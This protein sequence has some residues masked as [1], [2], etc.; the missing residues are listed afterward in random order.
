MRP[1]QYR[2]NDYSLLTPLFKKWI[3]SPLIRFVPWAIPANI[4]TLVSNVFV[5]LGLL[6][7]LNPEI[8]RQYTALLIALCLLAYLIGDHLDGMQAKRTGT[9]SALGEFCDHYLD[10]FNN[11]IVVFTMLA[12]FDVTDTLIIAVAIV[13]SY[14]AHMAVFYE[15]FKTGWLT[16]ERI[17]S[18]EGVLMAALLIG[19]S[20]YEPF[21]LFLTN[22]LVGSMSP[23]LLIIIGSALG[24][25]ITFI[26]TWSRT[27]DVRYG[28]LLFTVLL[29]IV[30][31]MGVQVFDNFQLFVILTLY[32]SLYV[33]R[34]M[35]G[36]LIDGVETQSD[37]AVPTV[38]TFYVMLGLSN[39]DFVFWL[40]ALYLGAR[41][42]L[43]IIKTFSTLR[44][45][46]VW[47]NSRT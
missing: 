23:A 25:L 18:L 22:N 46:W 27:P 14:L 28:Y 32:S 19:C 10:A 36:H 26:Q 24:A 38:I 37:W 11:G 31:A 30:G 39:V 45:Y 6:L 13:L 41:I 9:G 20:T 8:F 7:T 16:F 29:I 47:Q 35:H 17:G 2:C 40:S 3:I 34:I 44:V 4:I 5:Y 21:F 43:L 15:Q 42:L 1:Y 33:G 12:F